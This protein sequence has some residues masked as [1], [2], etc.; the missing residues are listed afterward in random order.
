MNN[1]Q[2]ALMMGA[3]VVAFYF[4]KQHKAATILDERYPMAYRG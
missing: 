3:A 2:M 4:Y 1:K